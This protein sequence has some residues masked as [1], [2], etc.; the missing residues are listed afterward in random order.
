MKL[1][2][3]PR[4]AQTPFTDDLDPVGKTQRLKKSELLLAIYFYGSSNVH[5]G[6][7]LVPVIFNYRAFMSSSGIKSRDTVSL[8]LISFIEC[9]FIAK[10]HIPFRYYTNKRVFLY[11][12]WI[13]EKYS[14]LDID[15]SGNI[16]MAAFQAQR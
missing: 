7:F 15:I 4:H 3:Y 10:S 13:K 1:Q 6:K 16:T 2:D 8:T 14:L 9:Q 12:D 5:M 11:S